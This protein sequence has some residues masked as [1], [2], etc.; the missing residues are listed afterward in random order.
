MPQVIEATAEAVEM[1]LN[2]PIVYNT[3]AYDSLES[4]E[5]LDGIVDVYMPDF[6]Y[7]SAERSRKYMKAQNYPEAARTAIGAM[8]KQVGSLT[9]DSSGLARQG[10]LV[11]HLVMP[12]CLDET[13][14]ILEWI[15]E[16]L[17]RKTYIN[18]M[19]QYFPAG[20]VSQETFPELSRRLSSS[21]FLEARQIAERL[22]LRLDRR[23]S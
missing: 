14:A 21:E 8:Y 11:R 20:K 15:A 10:L 12:G 22:H 1:G 7:W 2:L 16:E 9:F 3:S 6:K 4:I 19:D 17:G 18:L 23:R 13:R 5:L